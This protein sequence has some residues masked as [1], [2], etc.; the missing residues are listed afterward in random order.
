MPRVVWVPRAES[1]LEEIAYQIGVTD[2]RPAVAD[3]IVDEIQEKCSLYASSPLMGTRLNI[4]GD[5][6]RVFTHKRWVYTALDDGILVQAV[7][8]GA[9]DF[10]RLFGD[11]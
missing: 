8:D 2:A 9:R 6:Y 1:D 4:G 3:K 11:I 10:S 7:V 5:D